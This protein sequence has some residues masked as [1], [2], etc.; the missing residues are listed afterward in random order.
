MLS[1]D[2]CHEISHRLRR[3]VLHLPGGVGVDSKRESS[4]V[5]AQHTADGFHVHSVL[6]GQSCESVSKLVDAENDGI[7]VE[8]ENGI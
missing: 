5:V 8:V 3:L 7:L 6:E 1:Q 4:V 2:L